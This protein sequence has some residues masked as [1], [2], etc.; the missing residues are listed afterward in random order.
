M[1]AA[2]WAAEPPAGVSDVRITGHIEGETITFVLELTTEMKQAGGVLRLVSGDVALEKIEGVQGRYRL[3]HEPGPPASEDAPAADTFLLWLARGGE[4]RIRATFACRPAT[5]EGGEWRECAFTIPLSNI[6]LLEVTSD[7]PDLEIRFP[8]AMRVRREVEEGRLRTT[9][10]LGVGRGFAVRW[11]PQVHELAGKLVAAADVNAIASVTAGALRLDALVA[12]RISQGEAEALRV[13]LPKSLSV[14][15]VRGPRIQDWGVT[16]TADAQTLTVTLTQP[17][18]QSYALQI[19]AEAPLAEFPTDLAVPVV[20]PLDT[21]RASGHVCVGSDSAVHL[22]ITKAAGLT[23]I[24]EAAFPLAVIDQNSP[25]P[26]PSRSRFCYRYAAT[27]FQLALT[28]SDIRPL[29]DASQQ[30]VVDVRDDDLLLH[31]AIELDIRDAPIR[32]C[33]LRIPAGFTVADVAGNDVIPNGHEVREVEGGRV[34]V[35]PFKTPVAGRRLVHVRL[36]IGGS[37]LDRALAV[38]ALDVL[39]A[40]GERGYLVIAAAQGIQVEV[41]KAEKLREAHTASVPMRVARAQTAFRFREPGWS[42]ELLAKQMAPSIRCQFFHLAS[43]GEGITY[44]SATATL[45]VTGAPVD[46]LH[47]RVPKELQNVE[48]VGTDVQSQKRQGDVWTVTLRRRVLRHCELLITSTQPY[49]AS[50]GKITVGGIECLDAETQVGY[51]AVASALNLKLEDLGPE[52][53]HLMS[54]DHEELP[55]SYRKFM[56]APVLRAYKYVRAPHVAELGIETYELSSLLGA[57]IDLMELRTTVSEE[58]EAVTTATYRVKN[59]DRQFLELKTPEDARIWSVEILDE[60][61]GRPTRK[62]VIPSRGRQGRL[63]IPLER[64]RDPSQPIRV[65]VTYGE[66]GK[67]A[68]GF[69]RSYELV[70]PRPR[71]TSTFVRWVLAIPEDFAFASVTSAMAHETPRAQEPGLSEVGAALA[72]FYAEALEDPPWKALVACG[73]LGLVAVV[74]C[75]LF[76]RTWT[77]RAVLAVLA[78]LWLVAGLFA[79][80]EVS[81]AAAERFRMQA[82]P[83]LTFTEPLN[84]S[85]S[86]LGIRADIVPWWGAGLLSRRTLLLVGASVALLIAAALRRT[87]RRLLFSVG[88]GALVCAA[89]AVPAVRGPAT[90]LFAW[91]VPLVPA[92]L[93]AVRWSVPAKQMATAAAALVLV[94]LPLGCA[95]GPPPPLQGALV[96][97]TELFLKVEEDSVAVTEHLTFRAEAETHVPALAGSAALMDVLEKSDGVEVRMTEAGCVL[98]VKKAG[99]HTVR[100]RFLVPLDKPGPDRWR[101]FGLS[102]P[103]SVMTFAHLTLPQVNVDVLSPVVKIWKR[104]ED[105]QTHVDAVMGPGDELAFRWRPRAR[106]TELEETVFF[107]NV[108]TGVRFRAGVVECAHAVR[109]QIAQG[110]LRDIRIRVPEGMAV[111][112][113]DGKGLGAWRFD[114]AERRVDVRLTEPAVGD[115]LLLLVTQRTQQEL[116][117]S[118]TVGVPEVEGAARQRGAVGL[119]SA[120][121]VQVDV[122]S[123]P[124]EMNADDFATALAAA[125]GGQGQPAPRHAYR[126]HRPGATL[127]AGARRVVPEVRSVEQAAFSV[128]DDR[129]VYNGTLAVDVTKAGRFSVDLRLPAGYDIDELSSPEVSHWDEEKEGDTTRVTVH[130]RRRLL[131]VAPIRV[132]LSRPLSALPPVVVVPRLEVV[133]AL[134]HTGTII[135]SGEQG[136]RLSVKERTGVSHTQSDPA[137]RGDALA[138][139]LLKLD[140]R[141]ALAVEKIEPR[142]EVDFLHV[143]NVSEGLVQGTTHLRYTIHN[144]GVKVF[145]VRVPDGLTG[146]EITGAHIARTR[147]VGEGS[148]IWEVELA[149]KV[150]SQYLKVRFERRFDEE[151]SVHPTRALDAAL[152]RGHV[153][154]RT[155]QKVQ[156]TPKEVRRPLR[157]A[158]PRSIPS[159]M[160]G[161]DLSDAA[162]CYYAPTPDVALALEATRHAAAEI[163]PATVSEVNIATVVSEEGHRIS[164]V[165]V[166][167][168]VGSK[169]VLRT[170]LPPAARL[171]SLLVDEKSTTPSLA[172]QAAGR[173]IVLI[174]LGQAAGGAETKLDFIYVT[175]K[176]KGWRPDAQAY[177]GPQFDLPLRNVRWT[178]HLPEGLTYG[179][180]DGTL[181][182]D[183]DT[184]D[185]VLVL[186]YDASRYD[187]SAA[188]VNQENRKKAERLLETGRKLRQQGHGLEAKQAL[189][190]AWNYSRNDRALNE[191]ARVEL[192]NLQIEQTVAGLVERRDLVR[193]RGGR[194]LIEPPADGGRQLTPEAVARS[195]SQADK[196]NLEEISQRLQGQQAAAQRLDW[197]LGVVPP[198]RGRVIAFERALQV[199]P[200]VEMRVSFAGTTPLVRRTATD[201]AW[202]LGLAAVVFLFLAFVRRTEHPVPP[203]PPAADIDIPGAPSEEF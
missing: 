173:P 197:P 99:E 125:L 49:Q 193:P 178:F 35:V 40:K 134:K 162:L 33:E 12:Y 81:R 135:V 79:A 160:G 201:Y 43:I 91:L 98:D 107:S 179:D 20:R 68:L 122:E 110:E 27:P 58:G 51:V 159:G 17:E 129:L 127:V 158:D 23:Q 92:A 59:L 75:V 82:A 195:L 16:E 26:L 103:R 22:K 89:A 53:R 93:L 172:G 34:L 167:L 70:A 133:D 202:L 190:K 3:L 181:E 175:P 39:G 50:G 176:Q 105:G 45:H 55:G 66:P 149:S 114:P 136:V 94:M 7:R 64:R 21:I 126:Y 2:A 112:S 139:K 60:T 28:A 9:A 196:D 32:E 88:I 150:Q 15:Q 189:Q 130:F 115:Y 123:H 100:L 95:T 153:V 11:K 166:L 182:P 54:I 163:L 187:E 87:R 71:I 111:T 69:G 180:F 62:R 42:L 157:R 61:D 25:R 144:A 72:G 121:D 67:T 170:E 65:V 85:Q 73:L 142:I 24:D 84:L 183:E 185:Q 44:G 164:H 143:A 8:N 154:V 10:I 14:T 108:V 18:R 124:P 1:G 131:G 30:V 137:A 78:G 90:A 194:G 83:A 13:A 106:Q 156:V 141:L 188:L 192:Q 31:S 52:E 171:W 191:D 168:R 96:D 169:R 200:N 120:A 128:A 97:R 6:R 86:E 47:F 147:E 155:H 29:L 203:A 148:G 48:F 177:T 41:A 77:G 38:S 57:V 146:L 199:E 138:F 46:R 104:E 119:Y 80:A 151:L 5:V 152:Q 113:V 165:R 4:H 109:F 36:E 174:P 101:R 186:R 56:S 132:A 118:V 184:L 19:Q 198:L 102:V 117:Y 63:L 116:P 37:P 140:W 161:R 76:K 145:R 74:L